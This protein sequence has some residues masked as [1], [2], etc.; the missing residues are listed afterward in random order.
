MTRR[1]QNRQWND[2]IDCEDAANFIAWSENEADYGEPLY[3]MRDEDEDDLLKDQT[4]KAKEDRH[5]VSIKRNVWAKIK[6]VAESEGQHPNDWVEDL[7][8][9]KLEQL[10][11]LNK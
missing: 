1:Q 6:K 9:E 10:S 3:A 8:N 5:A 11:Y 7:I 4:R 2:N